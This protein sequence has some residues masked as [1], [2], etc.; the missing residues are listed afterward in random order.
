MAQNLVEI[1]ST[2]GNP[3]APLWGVDENRRRERV[4]SFFDSTTKQTQG[5]KR[6]GFAE[7]CIREHPENLGRM[8]EG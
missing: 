6:K 3:M 1:G 8:A 7:R 4:H 5:A 2:P